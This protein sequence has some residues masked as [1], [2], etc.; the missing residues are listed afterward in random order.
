[1]IDTNI[2]ISMYLFPSASMQKLIETITSN[3]T[4]V[5]SSYV[6]DE[7]KVIVKRKFTTKYSALNTFLKELPFDYVYTVE[8]IDAAKYPSIRDAKDLPVLVSMSRSYSSFPIKNTPQI[9]S[10]Y[11]TFINSSMRLQ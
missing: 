10:T 7:L 3:H 4:I 5:L 11:N 2:L 1:M 9:R 8:Q 6:I